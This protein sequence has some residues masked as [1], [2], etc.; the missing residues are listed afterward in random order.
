MRKTFFYLFPYL[1]CSPLGPISEIIPYHQ[2]VFGL[3]S[4]NILFSRAVRFG[5]RFFFFSWEKSQGDSSTFL[6]MLGRLLLIFMLKKKT[7]PRLFRVLFL[8][9]QEKKREKSNNVQQSTWYP[10]NYLQKSNLCGGFRISHRRNVLY[11][12]NI[13]VMSR[14]S[15][16]DSQS[17]GFVSF[18][19]NVSVW[20]FN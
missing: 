3:K 16:H 6:R 10:R 14:I 11:T 15:V 5:Q 12:E 19:K 20:N 2:T 7:E 17:L 4:A 1:V 8:K 13:S 18:S 9:K